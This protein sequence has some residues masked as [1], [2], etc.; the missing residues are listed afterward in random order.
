M[1]FELLQL[2]EKKKEY[3]SK[4]NRALRNKEEILQKVNS[5]TKNNPKIVD[6]EN[7]KKLLEKQIN[8]IWRSKKSYE[9]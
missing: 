8:I 6:L 7:A 1:P 2:E 4:K 9:K 5:V 3:V